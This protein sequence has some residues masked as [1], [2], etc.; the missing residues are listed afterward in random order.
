MARITI[1]MDDDNSKSKGRPV[2]DPSRGKK[3]DYC[4]T[5]NIA[6]PK[7]LMKKVESLALPARTMTLTDYVV[8]LIKKDT[9]ANTKVYKQFLEIKKTL[10]QDENEEE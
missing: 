1:N 9:E 8:F 7:E 2:K 10:I 4:K 6:V 3:R 5:I